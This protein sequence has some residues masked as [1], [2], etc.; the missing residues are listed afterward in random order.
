[1]NWYNLLFI[2]FIS[3]LLSSRLT[4]HAQSL[5][6]LKPSNKAS[7][8]IYQAD[9][10]KADL[11]QGSALLKGNVVIYFEGYKLTAP[12]AEIIK[13]ES[14]FTARGGVRIENLMTIMTAEYVEIFFDNNTG[15]L[16]DARIESGQMLIQA[17]EIRKLDKDIFEANNSY[18]SSCL[19]CP[20]FISFKAR[21]IK[22]NIKKYV[23]LKWGRP[24]LFNQPFFIFPRLILPVNTRRKSGFILIE[25]QLSTARS[26]FGLGIP[27]FW[28]IKENQDLTITP[29]IYSKSGINTVLNFRHLFDSRSKLEADFAYMKD[30]DF[31]IYEYGPTPGSGR[32]RSTVANRWFFD[33]QNELYLPENFIQKSKVRLI[34]D[35]IYL[36]D[37]PNRFDNR[38]EPN[39]ENQISLIKNEGKNHFS[40]EVVYNIN[41][42]TES[43]KTQNLEAVHRT[44]QLKY[45]RLNSIFLK[46]FRFSFDSEYNKFSRKG[47]S[48]DEVT[49]NAAPGDPLPPGETLRKELTE[50]LTGIFDPSRGLIRSGHRLFLQPKIVGSFNLSNRLILLPKL[51]LNQGFY[52]FAPAFNESIAANAD[53]LPYSELA[54]RGYIEGELEL[55]TQFSKVFNKSWKHIV[56]PSLSYFKGNVF[57]ETDH[58]F[59][60]STRNLP[61]YRRFQPINDSDFFDYNHGIQFDYYDRIENTEVLKISLL[62]T[63]LRKDKSAN[64]DYYSQPIFFELSQNYD[65]INAESARPDP[66]STLNAL[67]KIKT[68]KMETFTQ[69]SHFHKIRKTNFSTRNKYIYQPGKFI[70]ISYKNNYLINRDNL[71]EFHQEFVGV[72]TGWKFPFVSFSGEILYSTLDDQ[73]Q[74][75]QS[76]FGYT[77]PG[78]C[79]EIL[80][81]IFGNIDRRQATNRPNF[82]LGVVWNFGEGSNKPS[83]VNTVF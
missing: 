14:R 54:Q 27:Y 11:D 79:L 26:Q 81:N 66:W 74:Q 61:Y 29:E 44:P 48:Y 49:V 19:S 13:A 7:D 75:W 70:S 30:N 20:P 9:V 37:F 68:E 58:V 6:Y 80:V 59:F 82:K 83:D 38:T 43:F 65:F 10:I 21:S 23:D 67:I 2:I 32:E 4:V 77:P 55:K 72:G 60:Q 73:V 63:F 18:F 50:P 1:M 3:E 8:I 22:T 45:N 15:I 5:D 12:E 53:D 69:A 24:Q 41:L 36:S 42:L 16:K 31:V 51:S 17:K 62:Q 64:I 39:I 78:K 33:F 34:S 35:T 47:L 56:E 40:S 46:N 71:E 76:V 57:S 52:S 28:A 25:P